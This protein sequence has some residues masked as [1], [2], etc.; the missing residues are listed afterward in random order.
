MGNDD[1]VK[2]KPFEN[3]LK[4]LSE[5]VFLY[6]A[7][8]RVIW[9]ND[10]LLQ[11]SIFTHDD[12]LKGS[13]E[14]FFEESRTDINIFQ[15]VKQ[16]KRPITALQTFKDPESGKEQKTIVTQTPIIDEHEEVSLIVGVIRDIQ[17]SENTLQ[18]LNANR[19]HLHRVCLSFSPGR[20]RIR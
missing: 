2:Y 20:K 17:E 3:I 12:I 7:D 5:A 1:S 9:A 18:V 10:Y 19:H 16:E 14:Q 6:N 11:H 4:H 15:L 13:G 8:G